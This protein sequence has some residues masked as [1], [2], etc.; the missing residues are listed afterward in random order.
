MAGSVI[1][2]AAAPYEILTCI[3]ASRILHD[4]VPNRVA[5]ASFGL[6]VVVRTGKLS[7]ELVV[8]RV[9]SGIAALAFLGGCASSNQQA[10]NNAAT[11][12][13]ASNTAA[14]S[15]VRQPMADE[16]RDTATPGRYH[17]VAAVDIPSSQVIARVN[18]QPITM[19]ELQRP[20]IE[21]YGLR[22]L[23][24][25]IQLNLARQKAVEQKVNYTQADV[26]AE[27]ERT[28]KVGFKDAPKEDYPN[29]LN[30]LL[31]RQGVSRA[32][33]DMVIE[34]NTILRRIAEPQLKDKITD[35]NLQEM[36]NAVY[37]ETVVVRH[38]QAANPLEAQ[39]ARTR[40]AAGEK[41]EDV[42][43]AA[44]RNARTAALDGE[45]PPFTRQ[46][47]TW[48]GDWGKVPEGF[49]QWAFGGVKVGD[50]SDPI[51]ADGAYHILK[52]ERKI[53][54][55]VIKFEDV[56]ESLRADLYEKLVDQGVNE[57]RN[58][59]GLMA[60]RSM[61]IE[62]PTLRKQYEAKVS[63]Q[64]K[65]IKDEDRIRNEL[66]SRVQAATQAATTQPATR[67]TTQPAATT[68]PAK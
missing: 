50:I 12:P 47:A 17:P 9:F 40:L 61:T 64:A 35:A 53:Q 14:N 4:S 59:L 8:K 27:L 3:T 44:S 49:K 33:F 65:A 22:V 52:L 31:E 19:G 39:Q 21:G 42:V 34:T 7:Q 51:Q 1:D 20:L 68:A 11:G 58:Q 24:F 38:I 2:L 23:L 57:L 67:A 54:P 66:R 16:T 6:P 25:Q 43:R 55:K 56:K 48:A 62:D 18:G 26:V 60:K 37:G 46:T 32:E 10:S 13:L 5:R 36:F 41:W 30:Q 63:E 29:L 15:A 28:L 45:L